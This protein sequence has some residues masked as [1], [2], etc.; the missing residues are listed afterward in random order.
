M[1]PRKSDASKAAAGDEVASVPAP[2]KKD[3]GINIEVNV[4]TLAF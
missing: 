2:S 3:D 1:P 4:S